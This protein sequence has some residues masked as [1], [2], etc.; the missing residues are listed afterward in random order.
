MRL[1]L[2][3][4]MRSSDLLIDLIQVDKSLRCGDQRF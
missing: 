1:R 3:L 4:P 2:G